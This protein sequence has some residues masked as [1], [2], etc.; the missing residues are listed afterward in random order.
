MRELIRHILR[1]HL[2]EQREKWSEDK[3]RQI[4]QNY[5]T[6]K[7]FLSNETKAAHAMRRLGLYDE[8]TSHMEKPAKYTDDD[9]EQEARKYT[10]QADF[11]KGSPLHYQ[12]FKRRKLQSKFRDFL[13]TKIKKWTNEMLK[14]EA[15]KYNTMIDFL[16]NS[17]SA[18]KTAYDRGILD[19]ITKHIPKPKKW[20]Y[21]EALKETKKYKTLADFAKNSQ[22]YHQ[23]RENGWLEEF[24]KFLDHSITWSKEMA[25]EEASK[26]STKRDFKEKSPKAYSAAHRNGWIDEITKHMDVLGDKFNRMVYV[27]EFPDKHVYV[28]LT[29]DKMRRNYSHLDIEKLT[30]PVA[31]H[32]LETGLQPKYKEVSAYISAADAQNLEN[33]TMEKYKSEGWVLLNRMKGGGLGACKTTYTKDQILKIAKKYTKRKDFKTKDAAAYRVAQKY[34]W[35]KDAVAHIP[36]HDSTVWNYEKTQELASKVNSR[37]EL[38]Y[39]SQSAYASA[40]KNGWLDE[41]FP[42]K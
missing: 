12:A 16:N 41:F 24:K 15:L 32:I 14:Q 1:E 26:Y 5:S 37:A 13:P 30:S 40:L 6:L 34:G 29:F 18:Y 22:A 20:S 10:N 39:A 4:S 17:A 23:S 19:D 3:L 31:K 21:D 33:C 2:L 9:I 28:G 25:A 8:M 42:K 7:D 36:K 27:Y 38:K 11:A 35:L